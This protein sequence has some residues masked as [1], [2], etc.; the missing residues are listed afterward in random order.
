MA[1]NDTGTASN[2][3]LEFEASFNDADIINK[4]TP[5]ELKDIKE[6]KKLQAIQLRFY[7]RNRNNPVDTL[8]R[9][10]EITEKYGVVEARKI[11]EDAKNVLVSQTAEK[12]LD[13]IRLEKAD[14]DQKIANFTDILFKLTLHKET[15]YLRLKLKDQ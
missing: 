10:Q 4:Y 11:L 14:K 6:D 3:E 8:N 9:G 2:A 1:A 12:D 7:N 5:E 15:L 13:A